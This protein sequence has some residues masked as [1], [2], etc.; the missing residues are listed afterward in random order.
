[1]KKWVK[2]SVWVIT[3]TLLV[4]LITFVSKKQKNALCTSISIIF[5]DSTDAQFIDRNDIYEIINQNGG[6]F[7]GKPI[8][9]INL[10][11]IEKTL[12]DVPYIK[13]AEVYKKIDGTLCVET[14]QRIPSLRIIN[15]N[16]SSFYISDEGVLMPVSNKVKSRLLVANGEIKFNP[17]YEKIVNIYNKKFNDLEEI[18]VLRDVH[19]LASYINK[20][21]FWKSQIQQIYINGKQEFEII[22]LV[23]DHII[24]FGG[25]DKHEEKFANLEATYKKG[26]SVKGWNNYKKIS[27]KYK[28]Q[29]ICSKAE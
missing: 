25:I 16:N 6:N 4:V 28:N 12:N 11:E 3:A 23:G 7:I 27:L 15:S 26:F 17:D 10:A 8:K 13:H 5:I 14:K 9:N 24:E 29:V 2:I 18:Q 19:K 20:N 1:M 21:K 22:P